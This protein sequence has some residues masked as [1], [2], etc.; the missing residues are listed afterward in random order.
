MLQNASQNIDNIYVCQFYWNIIY[1]HKAHPIKVQNSMV[2]VHLQ[3]CA[4]IIMI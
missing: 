3:S 4:A 1:L 2:L